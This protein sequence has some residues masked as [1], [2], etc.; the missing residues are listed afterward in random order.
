MVRYSDAKC[1]G[2]IFRMWTRCQKESV[3]QLQCWITE[4]SQQTVQHLAHI[5]NYLIHAG[6]NRGWKTNVC[7]VEEKICS[8]ASVC[9]CQMPHWWVSKRQAAAILHCLFCFHMPFWKEEPDIRKCVYLQQKRLRSIQYIIPRS[10]MFSLGLFLSVQ[11]S[12]ELMKA[13]PSEY[14]F[15]SSDDWR[16]GRLTG[17]IYNQSF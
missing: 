15:S 16:W 7:G 8:P 14:E 1:V 3:I 17:H 11:S 12:P 5:F 9:Q 4:S 10:L 13:R 2:F 6:T